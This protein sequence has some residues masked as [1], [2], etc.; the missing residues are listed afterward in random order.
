MLKIIISAFLL[1]PLGGFAASNI[2]LQSVAVD[3]DNFPAARK[4]AQHYVTHCISCHS[5]K[6]IRYQQLSTDLKMPQD[7]VLANLAPAGASIYDTM[8]TAMDT[9]DA[10]VWFGTPPPDLSLV[11][12]SRGADW[13]YSYLK[14]F[15][16]DRDKTFGVNNTVYKDTGMPHVLWKLQGIQTPV[17]GKEQISFLQ[18]SEKGEMSPGEFE[19][20]LSELVNFLVYVGEPSQAKRQSMGKYVLLFLLLFCVVAY[21][22]KKEYWRDIH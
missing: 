17:D 2:Q 9:T 11:A 7:K 5:L 19:Q 8:Q 22:L 13:I 12:R 4:G 18:L 14:G 21:L 6:Y 3:L 10:S 16:A 20:M 1:L 15:Y